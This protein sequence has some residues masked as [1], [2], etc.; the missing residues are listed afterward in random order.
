LNVASNLR[1][2]TPVQTQSDVR[3]EGPYKSL[4]ALRRDQRF[5]HYTNKFDTNF[6]PEIK[7]S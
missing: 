1:P 5:L 4:G 2:Q 3:A 7:F 6:L